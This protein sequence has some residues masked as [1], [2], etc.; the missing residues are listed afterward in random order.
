[1][2]FLSKPL[3]LKLNETN[4]CHVLRPADRCDALVLQVEEHSWHAYPHFNPPEQFAPFQLA[5][6]V[7]YNNAWEN[8]ASAMEMSAISAYNNALLVAQHLKAIGIATSGL[9]PDSSAVPDK[10]LQQA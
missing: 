3:L 9:E 7:Y 10:L 1:M 8:A 4:L 2:A 6:G 5:P